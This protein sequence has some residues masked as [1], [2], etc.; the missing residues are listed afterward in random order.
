MTLS[1]LQNILARPKASG[2]LVMARG[3]SLGFWSKPQAT[4]HCFI[5][6]AEYGQ[7]STGQV[8]H[9]KALW[10]PQTG[11][12]YDRTHWSTAGWPGNSCLPKTGDLWQRSDEHLNVINKQ[13]PWSSLWTNSQPALAK[14]VNQWQRRVTGD[15]VWIKDCHH[16]AGK[17]GWHCRVASHGSTAHRHWFQTT[18][19]PAY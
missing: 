6:S 18:L 12:V 19:L 17:W 15:A 14:V 4:V 1:F 9:R 10:K 16:S 2:P 5:S 11:H 8:K 7:V 13:R 3:S